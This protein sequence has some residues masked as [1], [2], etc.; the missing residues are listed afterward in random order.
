MIKLNNKITKI[1]NSK[2]H[3]N[4]DILHLPKILRTIEELNFERNN[5]LKMVDHN[6]LLNP[7][8]ISHIFCRYLL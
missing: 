8:F 6:E 1:E 5:N 2:Q 7:A 3:F 4:F